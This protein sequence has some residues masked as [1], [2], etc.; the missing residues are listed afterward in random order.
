MLSLTLAVA[1]A[2]AQKPLADVDTD[3]DGLSD[4]RERHKH[5]TDPAKA[6]S[7]GDGTNDG[8]W[9]ERR[10]Y[11][12][13]LRSIVQVLPP[14]TDDVLVDD[15]QDARV[16]ERCDGYVELEVIHY[17]LNTVAEAIE[18]DAK[19]RKTVATMR[20]WLA[21]GPTANWDGE[22]AREI[23]AALDKKGIDVKT[24]DDKR[25]VEQAASFLLEH[26]PS[27]DG[28]TTFC[29]WFPM[30]VGSEGRAAAV[31]PGLEATVESESAKAGLSLE[32]QWERELFAKGMWEHG[33]R[34]TCTSSA[35]YLNGSLRA[36]GIPTRIVLCIPVVDASDEREIELVRERLTHHRVRATI[37]E[38]LSGLEGSWSSHT[39]NEV[40]VGGRWRR[41]N[42]NKLGQNILDPGYFGLMTHVATFSDWADGDMARTWGMRQCASDHDDVFGGANPY[43]TIGLS[44]R[45]G[46]HAKVA[47]EPV[48]TP[49]ELESVTIDALVWSDDPSVPKWVAEGFTGRPGLLA[50]TK[51]WPGWPALK[52]FAKSADERFFLAAEGSTLGIQCQGGGFTSSDGSVRYLVLQLGGGDW[53]ALVA[54]ANYSLRARNDHPTLRWIVA[55]DVRIVGHGP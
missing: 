9:E 45:F 37:L 18:P 24:L 29:S 20:E 6:D 44:D 36:L 49:A 46:V 54:G 22:M 8:D 15:Y 50:H 10:E 14:V 19:W 11:A 47:N 41:L 30:G 48:D 1:V 52:S 23:A 28:F 43:S 38:G 13:T 33:T 21:P 51:E 12:Y 39:F 4:F 2:L 25:L 27:N 40:F 16:L 55:P 42:Y 3:R 5:F 31:F 17:P 26:A 32:E 53:Q 34:G 35:I 7:D